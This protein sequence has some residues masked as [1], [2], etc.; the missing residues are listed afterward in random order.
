MSEENWS[1]KDRKISIGL[2]SK[3]GD[4][5]IIEYNGNNMVNEI[6]GTVFN[7]YDEEIIETLREKLIEDIDIIDCTETSKLKRWEIIEEVLEIIDKQFGV[8]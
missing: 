2:F 3:S 4:N 5:D 6:A 8:K 7:G 1:L